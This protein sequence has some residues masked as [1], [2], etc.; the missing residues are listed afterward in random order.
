MIYGLDKKRA[1][2]KQWRISEATLLLFA[3]IGGSM[4]AW[5][6][7]RLFHHKTR[8]PK[9]YIGVPVIFLVQVMMVVLLNWI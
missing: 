6:G 4:G 3:A 7:M 9:F 1:E 8:H 5:L 2:K